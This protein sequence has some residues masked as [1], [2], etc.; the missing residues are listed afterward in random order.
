MLR[1]QIESILYA[2]V[3][4]DA[5]GVPVEFEKR[6]SYHIDSMIGFGTWNQPKGSWSDD[7]S[8]SLPLMKNLTEGGN[9]AELM[10]EFGDYV[11]QGKYTPDGKTYGIGDT[12]S[13]A[14]SNWTDGHL[15]PTDCGD[16]S[17]DANGNGAL[18]RLAS[19]AIHL[20]DESDIHKRLQLTHDYTCLTHRH[21]RTIL[22]SY[23]YLEILHA[24]L[25]GQ[26]LRCILHDLP[27]TFEIILQDQPLELAEMDKFSAMFKNNFSS[28]LLSEIKSTGYVVDTLL[29]CVWCVLNTTSIDEAVLMAV[30]LGDDTDTIAS[31]TATLASCENLSDHINNDWI[32]QLQNKELL[33]SIIE[34]FA[35]KE[36]NDFSQIKL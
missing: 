3:V 13:R 27:D 2:A 16:D 36:E 32:L 5:M 6:G 35:K 25:N 22:A 28:L 33:N 10:H 9:Y 19:L 14:I 11:F 17:V 7:T 18:M 24:L 29:A 12:C 15:A 26:P 20:I 23:I 8:F 4:G 30:N 34:P 21:P 1:N 31:I